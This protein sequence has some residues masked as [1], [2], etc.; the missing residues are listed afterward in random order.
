MR[1]LELNSLLT[2]F[3]N[4][5]LEIRVYNEISLQLELGLY[6]RT[7]LYGLGYIIYFERNIKD[8]LKLHGR[9]NEA[10][11]LVKREID[12]VIEKEATGELYA[13]EL[14]FPRNGMHPEEMFQFLI[15][16]RFVEQ[17]N[18]TGLFTGTY[19]LTLVDDELFYKGKKENYPYSIFR[20][21]QIN[22]PSGMDVK[23]PTGKK[24]G[25]VISTIKGTCCSSWQTPKASWIENKTKSKYYSFKFADE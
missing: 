16:I 13:I 9:E 5:E 10:A 8:I 14:K 7:R 20:N 11:D 23:V 6:L 18:S 17:L 12:I 3:M 24:K 21:S 19:T 15:D 2:D 4:S 1:H 22:I 25:L